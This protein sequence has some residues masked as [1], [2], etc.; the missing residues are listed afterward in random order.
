MLLP[1]FS[2]HPVII[3]QEQQGREHSTRPSRD[4]CHL[5]RDREVAMVL[6]IDIDQHRDKSRDRIERYD[7]IVF[8]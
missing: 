7:P 3:Q 4:N 8:A 2:K 5:S 6:R 1:D